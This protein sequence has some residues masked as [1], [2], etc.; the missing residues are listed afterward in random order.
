MQ[1]MQGAIISDRMYG[2]FLLLQNLHSRHPWRSYAAGAWMRRSGV[3]GCIVHLLFVIASAARQPR[4]LSL[5]ST[6][7]N[8]VRNV[9]E[10][11]LHGPQGKIQGCIL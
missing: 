5:Q 4:F 7:H 10:H 9:I 2:R 8:Y 11:A 6:K 3:L 1:I